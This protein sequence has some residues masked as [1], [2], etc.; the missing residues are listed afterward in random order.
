MLQLCLRSAF[1]GIAK[2]TERCG[3]KGWRMRM[4]SKGVEGFFVPHLMQPKAK[5]DGAA[6]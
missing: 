1:D 3:E 4:A 5:A 6:T 2:E